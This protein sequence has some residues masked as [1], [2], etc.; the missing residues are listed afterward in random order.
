MNLFRPDDVGDFSV[1][2]LIPGHSIRR[3]ECSSN[4]NFVGEVC[5]KETKL[6]N[7]EII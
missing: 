1:R 3:Y 5:R 6:Q 2:P 7:V 4:W